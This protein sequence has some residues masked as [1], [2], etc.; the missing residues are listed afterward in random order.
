MLG[1]LLGGFPCGSPPQRRV[2]DYISDPL[3]TKLRAI[4]TLTFVCAE[5]EAARQKD[6][7]QLGK[8]LEQLLDNDA[9][10]LES[11]E[12][13]GDQIMEAVRGLRD[14]SYV[15]LMIPLYTFAVCTYR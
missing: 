7:A 8:T 3:S 11:L 15:N 13:R 9:N 2:L 4:S 5:H 14:V 12:S 6:Q 10:I 1:R